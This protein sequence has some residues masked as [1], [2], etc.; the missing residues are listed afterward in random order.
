MK[1]KIIT[2]KVDGASQGQWSNLLLEFNIIKQAWKS[3]GVD[4]TL[5]AP[6][7]KNILLWGTK[8][9]DYT[10]PTRQVSKR[11]QQNKRSKA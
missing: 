8:V 4:L 5:K 11:V 2:I 10:R 1:E 3:Y 9:N 6:G 7:L